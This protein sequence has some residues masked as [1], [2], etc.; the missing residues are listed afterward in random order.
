MACGEA[1]QEALG[2]EADLDMTMIGG[3]FAANGLAVVVAFS[4]EELI[5]V[6]AP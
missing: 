4:V 3:E 2:D 1:L 6:T 5:A